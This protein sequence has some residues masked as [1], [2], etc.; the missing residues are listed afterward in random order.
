MH[1]TNQNRQKLLRVSTIC[2][3]ALFLVLLTCG[4]IRMSVLALAAAAVLR[5]A[6]ENSRKKDLKYLE[7][8]NMASGSQEEL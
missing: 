6:G 1:I 2:F 8:G 5:K 4:R 3:L 7:A